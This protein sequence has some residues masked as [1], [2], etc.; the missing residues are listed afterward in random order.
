MANA[1]LRLVAHPMAVVAHILRKALRAF[2]IPL[3]AA[4]HFCLRLRVDRRPAGEF[5]RD[6]HQCFADEHRHRIQIGADRR[7]SPAAALRAGS[8]RR[9]RR[10][11]RPA[12]PWS[13]D[14][15]ESPAPSPLWRRLLAQPPGHRARDLPPRLVQ[16]RLVVRCLP[17]HQPLDDLVQP[18]AL[19]VLLLL[20]RE[21]IRP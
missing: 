12:V 11:H 16:D 6:F 14:N 2:S 7:A 21:P 5:R 13:A 18:S 9:P 1:L 15:R 10:G 4:L 8:T 17:R 19:S 20:G 3:P